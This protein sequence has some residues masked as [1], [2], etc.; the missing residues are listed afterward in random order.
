VE[1]PVPLSP[2]IALLLG[3]LLAFFGRGVVVLQVRLFGA[4]LGALAALSVV[5][6][7][8][9]PAQPDELLRLA[10]L[11]LGA[12][13]GWVLADAL[14]RVA[15]FVLGAAAG[16]GTLA[17]LLPPDEVAPPLA[18]LVGVL[19]G[20]VLL[21]TLESPL[22]KLATAALGGLVVAGAVAALLPPGAEPLP[23]LCGLAAAVLG[24]G[25]Q[26]ARR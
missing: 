3:L 6:S 19:L 22:L 7:L 26:L 23:W 13:I 8:G 11:G 17:R 16:A 21:V 4:L 20:G 10:A 1:P 18:W 9:G 24:A 14:R 12:V 2:W 15:V 25:A 5:A